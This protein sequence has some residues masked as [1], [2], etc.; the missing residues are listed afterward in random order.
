VAAVS[1]AVAAVA[2]VVAAG[3][4]SRAVFLLCQSRGQS[5]F[6]LRRLSSE[7]HFLEESGLTPALQL[8]NPG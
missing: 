6:S 1:P 4:V 7:R 2:A 5:T 3:D 8:I